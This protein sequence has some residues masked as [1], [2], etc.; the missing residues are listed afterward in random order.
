MERSGLRYA[1]TFHPQWL[2]AIAGAEAGE[3]EFQVTRTEWGGL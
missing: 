3:V 2:D 1:R